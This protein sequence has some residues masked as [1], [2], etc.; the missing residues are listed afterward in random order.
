MSLAITVTSQS[1]ARVPSSKSTRIYWVQAL[2]TSKLCFAVAS[3]FVRTPRGR[4]VRRSVSDTDFLQETE[5]QVVDFS[6]DDVETV[7]RVLSFLYTNS[8]STG[9][10]YDVEADPPSVP[11]DNVDDTKMYKA[12]TPSDQK[13][14]I[15]A[16]RAEVLVYQTADRLGIPTLVDTALR[17][18]T[19]NWGKDLLGNPDFAGL[20]DLVYQSTGRSDTR[21]RGWLTNAVILGIKLGWVD[22]KVDQ[23]VASHEPV[24]SFTFKHLYSTLVHAEP[25]VLAQLREKDVQR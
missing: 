15:A 10:L 23:L 8:Y 21:L 9:L 19:E 12:R 1:S 14:V 17:R 13:A 4:T 7:R 20:V 3:W 16:L 24:A 25:T 2:A 22:D 18:I 5:E 6:E 11:R